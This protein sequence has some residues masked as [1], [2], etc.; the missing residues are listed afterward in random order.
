MLTMLGGGGPGGAYRARNGGNDAR[1]PLSEEACETFFGLVQLPRVRRLDGLAG[2]RPRPR[3]CM[4]LPPRGVARPWAQPFK[5]KCMTF[6]TL[7]LTRDAAPD[8]LIL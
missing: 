7:T 3:C 2:A 1:H 5:I 6:L 8:I 4:P